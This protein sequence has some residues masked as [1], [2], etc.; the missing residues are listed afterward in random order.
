MA[1]YADPYSSSR[2]LTSH[3]RRNWLFIFDNILRLTARQA[4]FV[5]SLATGV[6]VQ[7]KQ[8]RDAHQPVDLQIQRPIILT[9]QSP[10]TRKGEDPLAAAGPGLPERALRVNLA[11]VTPERNPA[12]DSGRSSTSYSRNCWRCCPQP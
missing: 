12:F 5:N 6:S 10:R 8:P 3:A 1:P 4:Q 9:V 7:L 11:P 2:S